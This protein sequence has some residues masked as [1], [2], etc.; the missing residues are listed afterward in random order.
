MMWGLVRRLWAPELSWIKGEPLTNGA[1][2]VE[3]DTPQAKKLEGEMSDRQASV[4]QSYLEW[5]AERLEE[6]SGS[7][8]FGEKAGRNHRCRCR[9]VLTRRSKVCED[10]GHDLTSIF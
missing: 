9:P 2:G 1:F 4:Q 7:R 6:K 3:K 10:P 8:S 5:G